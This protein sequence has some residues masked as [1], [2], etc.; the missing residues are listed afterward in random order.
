MLETTHFHHTRNNQDHGVVVLQACTDTKFIALESSESVFN[1]KDAALLPPFFEIL[2]LQMCQLISNIHNT[3][4]YRWL[5]DCLVL[6]ITWLFMA[7]NKE[8]QVLAIVHTQC[9]AS[10]LWP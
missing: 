9:V 7:K 8:L 5:E 6:G 10:I 2:S 3:Q 4:G 1:R